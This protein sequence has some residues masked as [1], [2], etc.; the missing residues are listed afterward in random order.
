M[1]WIFESGLTSCLNRNLALVL[2]VSS[3][4]IL[5]ISGCGDGRGVRVPVSG[6]VTIDGQ[7]LAFGQIMFMPV[8]NGENNRPGG[9]SLNSDG[10]YRVSAYT[11]FDGLPP[12]QYKVAITGT[13]P[14][15]DDSQRWHAPK[16][17]AN[18][19]TSGLTADI[20]EATEELRFELSWKGEK[21]AEPFVEK[22]L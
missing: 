15:S 2:C 7:P 12:G 10:S 1:P 17:Y 16:K 6:A 14:I 13:E 21:P 18:V 8:V 4:A 3:V 19:A 22:N 11:A 9:G 20:E 5:G